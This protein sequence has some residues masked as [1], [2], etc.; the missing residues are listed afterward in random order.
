MRKEKIM[1]SSNALFW[2]FPGGI[3][4]NHEEFQLG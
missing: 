1:D 4:E 3:E 2:G